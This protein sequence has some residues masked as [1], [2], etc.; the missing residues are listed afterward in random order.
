MRLQ[1]M[2]SGPSQSSARDASSLL[3]RLWLP[4]ASLWGHCC[5]G[6]TSCGRQM[7]LLHASARPDWAQAKAAAASRSLMLGSNCPGS[8]GARHSGHAV[9]ACW[10]I[11]KSK[12][13]RTQC[14]QTAHG[15]AEQ[16]EGTAAASKWK[17]HPCYVLPRGRERSIPLLVKLTRRQ[18]SMRAWLTRVPARQDDGALKELMADRAR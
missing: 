9:F 18:K 4:C 8:H 7:P 10:F 14:E 5:T 3:L 12:L 17:K 13:L 2:P 16:Q 6:W 1:R 15:G 11:L